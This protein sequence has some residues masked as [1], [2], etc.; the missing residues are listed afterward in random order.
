MET[1]NLGK[2]NLRVSRLCL[3]T[4]TFGAQTDEATA[5]SMVNLCL[6]RGITFIDT[7]N[8]YNAGA[9][10]TILGRALKGRRDRVVLASKVAGKMGPD[11]D[12]SGLSRAA[13]LRAGFP[14]PG[15]RGT[16]R[17]LRLRCR[18]R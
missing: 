17:G 16:I 10:E 8:V 13:I 11:R 5:L 14:W 7:A 3:G 9:S 15:A 6:D 4:M 18:R 2:T 12:Q 1:L